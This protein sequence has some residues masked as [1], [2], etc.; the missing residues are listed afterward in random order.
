MV[1]LN[2]EFLSADYKKSIMVYV[3]MVLWNYDL[4]NNQW[5]DHSR[6]IFGSFLFG[7]FWIGLSSYG[8][9]DVGESNDGRTEVAIRI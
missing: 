2:V 9:Y 5:L 6:R 1:D 7:V 8:C 3:K 4:E